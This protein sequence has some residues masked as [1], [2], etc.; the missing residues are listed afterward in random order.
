MSKHPFRTAIE[1]GAS[2]AELSGLLA[3]DV[4]LLAPMLTMP[5]T[6]AA[7]VAHVLAC[8]AR[9]AAPIEYTLEASDERQ[10]FLMWNGQTQGF[11]LQAVTILVDNSQGLVQEIRVLMRPWPV[12]T[13]FRDDMYQLLRGEIPPGSWELQPNPEPSGPRQ[14]TP[15][16]MRHIESAP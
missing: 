8:A 2:E 9:A 16:A 4:V 3:D 1:N 15:I 14:F 12:V 13:L 11:K 10:T 6:G 7:Q 5:L